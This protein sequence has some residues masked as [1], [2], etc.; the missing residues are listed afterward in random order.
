MFLVVFVS[1]SVSNSHSECYK[2]IA[3]K[4]RLPY[5]KCGHYPTLLNMFRIHQQCRDNS[6]NG[7]GDP[8]SAC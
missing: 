3:M 7:L 8:I 1:L 6:L 4:L 2:R 5:W